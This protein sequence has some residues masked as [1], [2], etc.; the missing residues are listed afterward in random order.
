MKCMASYRFVDINCRQNWGRKAIIIP[1]YPPTENEWHRAETELQEN[2]GK[3]GLYSG[4]YELTID[5]FT[6]LAR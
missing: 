6:P 4:V 3:S 5:A 1:Q 2:M